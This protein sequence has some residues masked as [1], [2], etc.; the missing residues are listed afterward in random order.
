MDK[1]EPGQDRNIAALS[2]LFMC[3]GLLNYETDV[4]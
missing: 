2:I 3:D 4:N 1:Y